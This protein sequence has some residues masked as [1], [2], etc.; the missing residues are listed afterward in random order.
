MKSR[1]KARIMFIEQYKIDRNPFAEDSVRPLFVS[2]S[3]REI[4]ELIRQVS[5]GA[6][7]T[8]LISGSAGVGKTTL[9][10]QRIRGFRDL[11][12]SWVSPDVDT[13]EKLYRKLLREVGP[14]PIDGTEEE[15][16]QILRVYLT[17]QR[18]NQRLSVVIVDGLE[19]H[20]RDVLMEIRSLLQMRIKEGP[21]LQFVFLTRND[22]LV[23]EIL[24]DHEGAGP[25]I[26]ARHAHLTGFT[27]E[28]SQ[29]YIRI[30]LQGAGC[31]WANELVPDDVIL[32]IH[33]LTQGIVGDVNTL[34]SA[35]L[36]ELAGQSAGTS[37][38]APRLSAELVK[39]VG[40][41]MHLRHKPDSWVRTLDE[42]LSPDAVRVRDVSQ[43]KIDSA[44]LVV[45]SGGKQLA[46]VTL[47]RPRMLLGRDPGCDIS[48]DSSFLSRFQNLF[49]QTEG[50]WMIIDLN[51]TNGCFVNG[52]R[53]RE[54]RLRDGDSISVG[55]HQLRFSA[56]AS[57]G[58]TERRKSPRRADPGE[59]TISTD[60]AEER[61][62]WSG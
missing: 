25:R 52:R 47:D 8:L 45:T 2:Q 19:R 58:S 53:V 42:A 59:D 41:R 62:H 10:T 16:R 40:E 38:K 55:H 49:I 29:S 31:E 11:P 61:E 15:L 20:R 34:C 33:G 7:Q 50:G 46:E 12:L 28:E 35:A 30:C 17:H 39:A 13:T 4:S 24:S 56:M 23:D 54:H 3:M 26:R 57:R 60:I 6:L 43:L 1:Y 21:L 37:G 27:L 48:L 32:N 9:L 5:K 36:E 44:H 51:S 14:G 18:T 22:E